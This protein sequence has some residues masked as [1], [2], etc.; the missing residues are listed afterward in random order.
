MQK[1]ANVTYFRRHRIHFRLHF[2]ISN[3]VDWFYNIFFGK[4]TFCFGNVLQI[5][6]VIEFTILLKYFDETLFR[7]IKWATDGPDS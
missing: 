4:Q 2:R 1:K 5:P 3:M 7:L 6:R